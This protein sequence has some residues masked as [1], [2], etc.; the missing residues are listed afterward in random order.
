MTWPKSH[1]WLGE[2]SRAVMIFKGAFS[3]ATKIYGFWRQISTSQDAE[4]GRWARQSH[5]VSSFGW[6]WNG[7][8]SVSYKISKRQQL[9]SWERKQSVWMTHTRDI[10]AWKQGIE[11]HIASWRSKGPWR[12]VPP[13]HQLLIPT[14]SW[15]ASLSGLDSRRT[16]NLKQLGFVKL[17]KSKAWGMVVMSPGSMAGCRPIGQSGRRQCPSIW[18]SLQIIQ[19]WLTTDIAN[20]RLLNFSRRLFPLIHTAQAH[21]GGCLLSSIFRWPRVSL[22]KFFRL[23]FN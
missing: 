11:P 21:A 17:Q 5:M 8:L 3:L 7:L 14:H 15:L 16:K 13:Y 23:A 20:L 19:T 6:A 2:E 10:F 22:T 18:T 1:G 12:N 4:F 9:H